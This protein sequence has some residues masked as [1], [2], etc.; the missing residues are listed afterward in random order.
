MNWT[1]VIMTSPHTESISV[2]AITV[3]S[4][5]NSTAARRKSYPVFRIM[6]EVP[7]GKTADEGSGLRAEHR[8]PQDDGGRRLR[9]AQSMDSRF[10]AAREA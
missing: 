8:F 6:T 7:G 2:P 3:L 9:A 5:D 4:S 1:K 10:E